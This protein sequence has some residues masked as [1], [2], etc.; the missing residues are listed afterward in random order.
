MDVMNDI[1]MVA[2]VH[3]KTNIKTPC[4]VVVST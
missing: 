3:V 4:C 1:V 2:F